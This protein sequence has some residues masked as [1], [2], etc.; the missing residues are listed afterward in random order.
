MS[1]HDARWGDYL[2]SV[3]FL[4]NPGVP[5]TDAPPVHITVRTLFAGQRVDF[6][7]DWALGRGEAGEMILYLTVDAEAA[8]VDRQAEP[9]VF[10]LGEHRVLVPATK[11][12][13][14]MV[15]LRWEGTG[16]GICNVAIFVEQV[17]W[18]PHTFGDHVIDG[19]QPGT[20][21]RCHECGGTG[22]LHRLDK[23]P[24]SVEPGS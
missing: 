9:P 3:T 14:E 6:V 19:G 7:H 16:E 11:I 8:D 1:D 23:Q 4:D 12:D 15:P 18:Q 20:I 24:V 17:H 5:L 10:K 21:V 13:G 2:H 22:E